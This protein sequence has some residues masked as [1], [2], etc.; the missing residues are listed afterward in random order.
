MTGAAQLPGLQ[1]VG[2]YGALIVGLV[3]GLVGWGL[4]QSQH[5]ARWTVMLGAVWGIASSLAPALIFST[6]LWWP[7][8]L[9]G[10]QIIVRVAV[11]WYL[12]RA[13]VAAAFSKP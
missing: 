10:L 6:R 13:S 12:F 5:W 8:L 11:V 9:V 4:L 7:F 1:W 3:W 2:P